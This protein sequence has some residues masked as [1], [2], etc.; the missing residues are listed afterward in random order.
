[1]EEIFRCGRRR[2]MFQW[3]RQDLIAFAVF[4]VADGVV[5]CQ[6]ERSSSIVSFSPI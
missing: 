5:A 4:F 6:A 1:M 3:G 2:R